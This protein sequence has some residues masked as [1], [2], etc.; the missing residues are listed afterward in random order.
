[1]FICKNKNN[2]ADSFQKQILV[3]E[4]SDLTYWG[5]IYAIGQVSQTEAVFFFF[6]LNIDS[7]LELLVLLTW[8]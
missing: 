8:I 7:I 3:Q 6:Q 1:M 2:P 5:L 4:W